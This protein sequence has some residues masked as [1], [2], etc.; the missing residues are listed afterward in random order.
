MNG[1]VLGIDLG[2][3]TTKMVTLDGERVESFRIFDTDH[4]PMRKVRQAMEGLKFEAVTAT[5]YGRHLLKVEFADGVV[6]E[7]KACARGAAFVRPGCTTVVDI[8]GQD[9][10]AIRV[11]PDG[12]F[13]DFEMNDRCA[14][15]TGRFMELMARALGWEIEQF[16]REAL[17]ADAAVPISSMCTVFA[18]S[19]VVSLVTSG[20]DRRRIALGL[21][22]AIV[23]RLESLISRVEPGAEI[24]LVGGGA[25][26]GCIVGL[27]GERLGIPVFVP[28]NPQIVPAIGAALIAAESAR[29]KEGDS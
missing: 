10:K 24:L 6:S 27:L 29:G 28:E 2:S 12:D 19:E 26:N 8:G 3:R 16:W 13:D 5:G 7:I 1:L 15:G 14:A 23:V 18:E 20:G 9:C 4:D 25:K 11:A 22:H 21:H 17:A